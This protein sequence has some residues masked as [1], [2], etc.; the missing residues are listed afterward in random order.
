MV[1]GG[2]VVR[3]RADSCLRQ[4]DIAAELG[5][6]IRYK[7]QGEAPDAESNQEITSIHN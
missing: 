5:L 2:H 3:G 1:A 4:S 6:I 7:V